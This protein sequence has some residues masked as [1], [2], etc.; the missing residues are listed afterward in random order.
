MP[1]HP[2][3]VPTRVRTPP[4]VRSRA[5]CRRPS[6][7]VAVDLGGELIGFGPFC[8]YSTVQTPLV[9]HVMLAS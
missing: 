5:R 9:A 1:R 2:V 6:R 8:G 4:Q 3:S 7:P